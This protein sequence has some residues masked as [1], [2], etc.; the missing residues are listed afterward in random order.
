MIL[1]AMPG[2]ATPGGFGRYAKASE[3][4]AIANMR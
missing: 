1:A 4:N 2:K 3:S